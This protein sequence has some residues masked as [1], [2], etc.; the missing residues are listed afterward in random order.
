MKVY[1]VDAVNEY[2]GST[3]VA[4]YRS[5]RSAERRVAKLYAER[6]RYQ[7]RLHLENPGKFS[8]FVGYSNFLIEKRSLL[9]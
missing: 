9:P 5:K 2:E 8:D 4:V 1:I 6:E 3:L 7:E